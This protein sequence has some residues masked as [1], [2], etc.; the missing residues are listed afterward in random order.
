LKIR[1]ILADDHVMVLE[2]LKALLGTQ[3]DMEVVDV[4]TDGARLVETVAEAAPD[5]VVLDQFMP[6][7]TGTEVLS[8]LR[9]R[10]LACRTLL[11][12]ATLK[13]EV[14][15]DALRLGVSGVL[16]KEAAWAE[17]VQGIRTVHDG[18]Q[19]FP[20]DVMAHVLRLL[21]EPA[22]EEADPLAALTPRE[23]EVTTGV[24]S[25]WSNK[26]IAK[27]LDISEGTVK[28]HIHSIFRKLGVSNRV[29]LGLLA[30][31]SQGEQRAPNQG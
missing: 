12:T 31:K 5:V 26:R 15:R 21:G 23:H 6:G 22:R 11:L 17:L 8:E 25:G 19:F 29:Q 10:G 13:D 27:E 1:I 16:L 9:D 24:A 28:L 2:G 14:L 4:C 30:A 3:A 18:R 7:L 20:P